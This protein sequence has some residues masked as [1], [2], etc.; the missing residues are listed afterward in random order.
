MLSCFHCLLTRFE[1]VMRI[2]VTM[3]A[4]FVVLKLNCHSIKIKCSIK[5][6]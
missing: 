5:Y 1:L 6:I 2:I 3:L 4:P